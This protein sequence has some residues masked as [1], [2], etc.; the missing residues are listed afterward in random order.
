[1]SDRRVEIRFV[2]V[3]VI[4]LLPVLVLGQVEASQH[5][6]FTN[7]LASDDWVAT[8]EA[9]LESTAVGYVYY[10][11][12][13]VADADVTLLRDE[14]VVYSA[15]TAVSAS[16]APSF[17]V[18][19]SDPPINAAPYEL[20]TLQVEYSGEI[21]RTTFIVLPGEQ[22]LSGWLSSTC[23]PTEIPGGMI[24]VDTTWTAECGPYQVRSN[25]QVAA[26]VTLSI[27]AGATILFDADKAILVNG[28]LLSQGTSSALVTFT[29]DQDQAWAYLSF[30]AGSTGSSLV[31]TL[32]EFAGSLSVANNA[33]I[34]IDGAEVTLS[35][36][37]VRG[38]EG[39]GI[40][41]FNNGAAL[42][43]G[44]TVI[45]NQGRGISVNTNVSGLSIQNSL[46]SGNAGDGISVEGSTAGTISGNSVESNGNSGIRIYAATG[47]ITISHNRIVGNTASNGGGLYLYYTTGAIH[48]NFIVGN[49]A[50]S[51][52][53]GVYFYSSYD[54]EE[55]SRNY[56]LYNQAQSKSAA[57]GGMY[58]RAKNIQVTNNIFAGNVA[59]E[60]LT[61]HPGPGGGL[62]V[63]NYG[64]T[65]HSVTV[66]QNAFLYNLA[67]EAPGGAL[68]STDPYLTLEANT[69]VDNA[70]TSSPAGDWGA[71]QLG[72]LAGINNNNL[73]NN[74]T[75][76]LYNG[77]LL[78]EGTVNARSNWW[79]TTDPAEISQQI[80]D[81]SD[82]ATHSVVDYANWLTAPWI[83]AP[84][85]PPSGVAATVD[86]SSI[87]ITWLA[88][89]ETDLAGYKLYVRAFG[90]PI[91]SAVY[92]YLDGI[93]VGQV[94]SFTLACLS[95]GAYTIAATAYDLSA[96]GLDDWTDGNESWFSREETA[97]TFTVSSCGPP[98]APGDL[99]AATISA[100]QIALIWT[101]NAVDETSY[102]VERSPDG[103]TGWSEIA[104]LAANVTAFNNSGL[105][106]NTTYYYRVRAYRS[107]DGQYS[108]Y[109]NVDH[110]TTTACLPPSAPSNLSATAVSANQ[111]NLSWTDNASD[112]TAYRVE[113][114]LD[115]STGWGEI[116]S[117]TAGSTAYS[118]S[119]LACETAYYFRVRAYRSGDGQYSA[120]S[121]V[122]HDTTK[123]CG[124]EPMCYLPL[125]I[126]P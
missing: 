11:G 111:I 112:E 87:T 84:V 43:D 32:V 68:Y 41:V 74:H 76:D 119:D 10:D 49:L 65:S 109:S 54:L 80:Y 82:D 73:F 56:I 106:C 98:A 24:A 45:N 125:I 99:S 123:S 12:T 122:S 62:S 9:S 89:P 2:F 5:T 8:P 1:M 61:T 77:A 118:D 96:D 46:V 29:R 70:A 3:V 108:T 33:A 115:G 93:D 85:S 35:D 57:G 103:S 47:P 21:N 18:S 72:G 34:R 94:T 17:T 55:F 113:R 53:G 6:T 116:A 30:S 38:S 86:G 4:L 90:S 83:A 100:G 28:R 79:G 75:Y 15:T 91:M 22:I 31:D 26:G 81:W 69:I 121:T 95:P 64:G 44:L 67:V 23:G 20:L 71:L 50:T 110:D 27:E 78:A 7:Q 102:R 105:V 63:Y 126:R 101:D 58:L 114:S 51:S 39:D 16:G 88:N 104:S 37:V 25:L 92:G 60:T 107:G 19:L 124:L 40:Q 97:T 120:Y 66:R 36:V 42:M 14:V 48:D 13:P 117:L 52:G 59:S